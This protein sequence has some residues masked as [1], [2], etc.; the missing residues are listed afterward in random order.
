MAA[1]SFR[2]EAKRLLLFMTGA[3]DSMVTM[4]AQ[5]TPYSHAVSF[6]ASVYR[7]KTL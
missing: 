6:Q 7:K 1:Q 5:N 3:K 2:G 4:E